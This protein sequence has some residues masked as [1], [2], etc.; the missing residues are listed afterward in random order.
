MTGLTLLPT[1]KQ[2]RESTGATPLNARVM[3]AGFPKSGKSTLAANWAPGTTLII[4]TQHGT[5]LLPG[6]HFVKHVSNWS[7]FAS[8]VDALTSNEHAFKTVVLDMVDDLW[9]FVDKDNAG[10]GATLGTATDDYGRSGKN[11]EGAF[12]DVI[13]KLLTT[14]LGVWFLSHTKTVEDKQGVR[15]VPRLDGKVVTY[16]NGAVQFV[17]LAE[18]LGPKRVLHTAP[19]AK[20][21]AGSRVALPEPMEMDARKLYAAMAAGLKPAKGENA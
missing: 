15:Y 16:V 2:S 12:R 7:E 10:R 9:M 6:E 5:D 14:N 11:A 8:T 20:F 13:G 18:T 21:E 17:F 19:S 4:D 3:L 1:K